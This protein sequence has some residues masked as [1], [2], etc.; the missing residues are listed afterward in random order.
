MKSKG[1]YLYIQQYIV[2]ENSF[3][4]SEIVVLNAF[5]NIELS[6]P[7]MTQSDWDSHVRI[8]PIIL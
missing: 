2:K 8:Q 4:W 1:R 5:F 3:H 7:K 6:I